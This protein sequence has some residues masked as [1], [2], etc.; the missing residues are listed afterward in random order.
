M[1]TK[2]LKLIVRR[3]GEN[4]LAYV[5]SIESGGQLRVPPHLALPLGLFT[6]GGPLSRAMGHGNR[7]FFEVEFQLS[8]STADDHDAISQTRS[9]TSL[10]TKSDYWNIPGLHVYNFASL[11]H[12]KATFRVPNANFIDKLKQLNHECFQVNVL[13]IQMEITNEITEA[14]FFCDWSTVEFTAD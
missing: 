13:K 14:W 11:N 4:R 1:E 3:P 7:H 12:E 8:D 9:S 5:F 6:L 10:I 2:G